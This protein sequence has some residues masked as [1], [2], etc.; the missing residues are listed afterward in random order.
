METRLK[1]RFLEYTGS[2]L[3][4]VETRLR[5]TESTTMDVHA[6]RTV[7]TDPETQVV[8]PAERQMSEKA[9]KVL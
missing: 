1:K 3:G 8:A 9:S 5:A 2:S 6:F 4:S 7:Q